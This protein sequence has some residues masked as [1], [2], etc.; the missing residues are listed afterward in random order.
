MTWPLQRSRRRGTGIAALILLL[1]V[2]NIAVLGVLAAGADESDLSV[3]RAQ[4]ARAFYAAESAGIAAIRLLEANQTLPTSGQELDL[5]TAVASYES[6]AL[7]S[8]SGRFVVTGTSGE[9]QRRI[10]IQ[11]SV[12]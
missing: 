9:A 8:E 10:E 11:F 4:T 2:L 6:V 1:A 3:S 5:G 12:Q 7:T